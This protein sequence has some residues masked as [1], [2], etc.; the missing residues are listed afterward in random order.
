VLALVAIE[1]HQAAAPAPAPRVPEPSTPSPEPPPKIATLP[2]P[3][4]YPT[5]PKQNLAWRA[6]A[7]LPRAVAED[8]ARVFEIGA[9]DPRGL[10]Y[11]EAELDVGEVWGGSRT[12][13]KTHAWLLPGAA[14]AVTWTGIVYRVR[15]FGAAADA[16]ADMEAALREDKASVD[17][18]KKR[19]PTWQPMRWDH[20]LPEAVSVSHEALTPMRVAMLARL[21]EGD[22]ASR[23][24]T[25]WLRGSQQSQEGIFLHH[26]AWAHFDRAVV[27][28]MAGADDVAYESTR[29]LSGVDK[30]IES[31]KYP[32]AELHDDTV[33]RLQSKTQHAKLEDV[34]ALP[35]AERIP[36]LVDRLED[37]SARQWGQPGGVSLGEDPVVQALVK[38]GPDAVDPLID[39]IEKDTRLTRSVHFW[40]DFARSRSLLGVHEAAYV[41]LAGIVE[42]SFFHPAAT[43]DDLSSRGPEIR[44]KLATELRAYWAKWRGVAIEEK[45]YRI[46][47]DDKETQASW[48]AAAQSIVQPSNVYVVPGSMV[49]S[50]T[51]TSSS[52]GPVG[53]RGEPLRS[54]SG[55]SVSDLLERR[56]KDLQSE[57]GAAC[58]MALALAL[59]D[60]KAS[61]PTLS[62]QMQRATAGTDYS[63]WSCIARVTSA[64]VKAGDSAALRE[65][66]RFMAP[67]D[68]RKEQEALRALEPMK[69]WPTDRDIEAAAKTMF[70]AGGAW[71]PLVPVTKSQ[72]S[73]PS[74]E[75]AELPKTDLLRVRAF[76]EHVLGALSD[77]HKAGTLTATDDGGIH[78]EMNAGW[79]TG[80][81]VM[82]G[83]HA[84]P[85]TYAIRVADYYASEVTQRSGAP[86]FRLY[87]PEAERDR[88]LGAVRKYVEAFR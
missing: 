77:L 6:P 85:G 87:W 50:T 42:M 70:G 8:I 17:K 16:R 48:T 34:V 27:A 61:L 39:V 62:S 1:C 74:Y 72:N 59:W 69:A 73:G 86:P 23:V 82:Q 29:I 53:V 65:Y 28:H 32:I 78:I 76:R 54:K 81:S 88:A 9:A 63:R 20:A 57:P 21:G 40:R 75:L 80:T 67:I 30:A 64:R 13:V 2:L 68:P 14:H 84:T 51:V 4:P 66:A 12:Q 47:S 26:W 38:A 71:V 18:E 83:D 24:W 79:Q 35:I 7:A 15:S 52:S 58:E 10:E 41:A 5:A 55:P 37:V 46:L 11:R 25:A 31:D 60:P 33:R 44:K 45:W 36:A 22:L 43:G 19:N 56:V 49:W 3:A